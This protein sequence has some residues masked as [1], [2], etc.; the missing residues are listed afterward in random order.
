MSK[1]G[2]IVL[3]T[4]IAIGIALVILL[5]S[6]AIGVALASGWFNPDPLA[7]YKEKGDI[8]IVEL[9]GPI[10]DSSPTI[11]ALHT[12]GE[13]SALGGVLFRINSPGGGVSASQEIYA[14]LK[15]LAASKTVVV[16]MGSV[17]ASGGYYVACAGDK[18]FANLGT[19]TGS[20][21]VLMEN[22]DLSA[23]L[24]VLRI[25]NRTLKSGDFKDVGSAFRPMNPEER[26][27]LQSLLATMHT[28][29][30][31]AVATSRKL[32]PAAVRALA[33]GRVFTGEEAKAKELVDAIGTYYDA[34]ADLKKSLGLGKDAVILQK[35]KQ[36][37]P[38]DR[39]FQEK[40]LTALKG[41]DFMS[42]SKVML[43]MGFNPQRTFSY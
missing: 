7:V 40:A 4:S 34:L 26:R 22:F 12:I 30:I 27:Y 9:E 41:I 19:I 17:A 13:N 20:I 28:Q 2:R 42:L 5:V 35:P 10:F 37:N 21:G 23:I 16:S 31:D 39:W 32:D 18:L 15:K 11:D 38:L 6:T 24:D 8:A 25:E 33:N 3:G 29:F 14:E 36:A 43:N 1:T